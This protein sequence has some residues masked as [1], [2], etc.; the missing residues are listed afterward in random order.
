MTE[1]HTERY[2]LISKTIWSIQDGIDYHIG[3][4]WMVKCMETVQDYLLVV[5]EKQT[6]FK[7]TEKKT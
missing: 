2:Q 4:G 7:E 3:R 6:E 1:Q 5:Y